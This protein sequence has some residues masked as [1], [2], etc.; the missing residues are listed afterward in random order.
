MGASTSIANNF[1]NTI[2]VCYDTNEDESICLDLVEHL[3]KHG[4]H[5]ITSKHIKDFISSTQED[6]KSIIHRTNSIIICV[7]T[8]WVRSYQQSREMNEILDRETN[9]IY[10]MTN[11]NYTPQTNKE[12]QGI[13][14]GNKWFTVDKKEKLYDYLC[15]RT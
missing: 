6:I 12:L 11:I 9:I 3:E 15:K 13:I 5:I 14:K 2:F 4:Y 10:L 1:Q 8:T 7:S